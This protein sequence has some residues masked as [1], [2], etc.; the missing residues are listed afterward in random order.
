METFGS[1]N[2]AKNLFNHMHVLI[3]RMQLPV[4]S[5]WRESDE[6]DFHKFAFKYIILHRSS[7]ECSWSDLYA[8]SNQPE[9][10]ILSHYHKPCMEH[11]GNVDPKIIVQNNEMTNIGHIVHSMLDKM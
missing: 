2:I 8:L 6:N 7:V 10:C 1:N 5:G 4:L 3:S 9:Y 11:Y